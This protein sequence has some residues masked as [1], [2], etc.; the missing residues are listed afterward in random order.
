MCVCV[1]VCVSVY[2][3]VRVLRHQIS[4]PIPLITVA[5]NAI[6]ISI[7]EKYITRIY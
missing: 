5:L 2:L 3:C 7:N 1:C 6:I 4:Y